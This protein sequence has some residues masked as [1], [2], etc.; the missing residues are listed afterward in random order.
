MKTAEIVKAVF[1]HRILFAVL[2]AALCAAAI[3]AALGTR[4]TSNIFDIL[5]SRDPVVAAHLRASSVFKTGDSLYFSVSNNSKNSARAADE[6]AKRLEECAC[7]EKITG[8]L[9]QDAAACSALVKY[10]PSIFGAPQ[11]SAEIFSV[12]KLAERFIEAKRRAASGDFTALRAIKTDPANTAAAFAKTL[13]KSVV[14]DGAKTRNFRIV[15]EDSGEILVKADGKFPCSDSAESAKL[16]EKVGTILKRLNAEFP[17]VRIR[18]TGGYRLSAENAAIAAGESKNAL[19][20]TLAAIF[21]ICALSLADFKSAFAAALP[22]AAGSALAFAA[23]ALV[24]GEI[25]SIS[26]A[27]AGLAVGASVDY[28]VHALWQAQK[29]G[30]YT[31]EDAQRTA[32]YI[33]KPIFAAAGTSAAAFAILG[34]CGADGF[35]QTGVFG[36]VGIFAAA[37][38]SVYVLPAYFAGGAVGRA[39]VKILPIA[40]AAAAQKISASKTCFWGAVAL[41][42]AAVPAALETEFDGNL[43]AFNALGAEAK[44]DDAAMRKIWRGTLSVKSVFT[45]ADSPEE[46]L[47]TAR[48]LSEFLDSRPDVAQFGAHKLLV[49]GDT[50]AENLRK[51]NA[52]A[53][54]SRI[55]ENAKRAATAAG[56]NAGA[57]EAALQKALDAPQISAQK[58]FGELAPVFDKFAKQ[59][60]SKFCLSATFTPKD[61]F[62]ARRFSAELSAA[63]PRAHLIDPDLLGAR[64]SEISRGWLA[65]F[66]AV[67]LAAV[68]AYLWAA[69]SAAGAAA[70]LLSVSAGLVW[71]F[72]AIALLGIS[73][74]P[75]SCVFVIFAVCLAQDYAVFIFNALKNGGNLGGAFEPMSVAAATTIAAFA[76]LALCRHPAFSALGATAAISITAI[77]LSSLCLTRRISNLLLRRKKNGK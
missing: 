44:A 14:F 20:A 30:V 7:F 40:F 43:G 63:L 53:K 8:N 5:P 45:E 55:A 70:V 39:R 76:I 37:A 50:A 26:V 65:E 1:K 35:A 68:A 6:L 71:G 24:F 12:K 18:W 3:F 54:E 28:A 31:L 73:I 59:C 52:F 34:I 41:T 38:A 4:T 17:D 48:A 46:L 49:D 61:G 11:E 19:I 64:I 16:A 2:A 21:A 22:S 57:M 27:F 9:A 29:S 72:A 47:K 62:D 33:A 69:F 10:L 13:E 32:E 74:N 42:F 56:L 75:I 23:V 25:S 77:L 15:S 66:A 60:G 67:S 58:I 36:V 51:W